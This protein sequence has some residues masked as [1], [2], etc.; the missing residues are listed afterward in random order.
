MTLLEKV[1]RNLKLLRAQFYPTEEEYL[2]IWKSA[3]ED[4]RRHGYTITLEQFENIFGSFSDLVAD[5]ED[6]Q[7]KVM[8]VVHEAVEAEE[9]KKITGKWILPR[10]YYDEMYKVGKVV[11]EPH[12][13]AEEIAPIEHRTL[14][15]MRKRGRL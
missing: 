11:L 15:L 7:D 13:K 2:K 12:R 8:L 6:F 1:R 4:L 10:D 9:V 5:Y 14:E 3:E